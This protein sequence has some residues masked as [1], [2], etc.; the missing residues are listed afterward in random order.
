MSITYDYDFQCYVEDGTIMK[1]GHKPDFIGSHGCFAC[2]HA[3][4]LIAKHRRDATYPNDE[5]TAPVSVDPEQRYDEHGQMP[6]FGRLAV[7]LSRFRVPSE[8]IREFMF[9]G[10]FKCKDG[11]TAIYANRESVAQFKHRDTSNS[12]MID[13]DGYVRHWHNGSYVD[14]CRNAME[15]QR[16]SQCFG[17]SF[18][19]VVAS[20]SA[21]RASY[22]TNFREEDCGGAFDGFGV[23]SDADPGL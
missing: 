11:S 5:W 9:M 12:V 10:C 19:H 15:A 6:I 2:Q 14:L 8:K 13:A 20:N 22:E 23:T 16:L 1:C 3:G 18:V 4:E 7:C 21:G 17:L